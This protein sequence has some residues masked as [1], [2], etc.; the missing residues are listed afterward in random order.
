M[1]DAPNDASG[2]SRKRTW[3]SNRVDQDKYNFAISYEANDTE[4]PTYTRTYVLPREGYEPLGLLS[5][6]PFD[7]FALMIGEQALTEIEPVELRT[8]YLKVVRVF[9]TLPGPISYAIEYPYGG[10]LKCPRVTTKQKFAH[11]A[12]PQPIGT[13]CPIPN[14]GDAILIGQSIQQ[15]EY[16]AVD[17]VQSIYDEIPKIDSG[18]HG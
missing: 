2:Q 6:D 15:T 17:I 9:A 18:P 16:G 3:V 11:Q 5:P 7:P 14:Y 1:G 10:D 8:V 13:R 12:F 4:F